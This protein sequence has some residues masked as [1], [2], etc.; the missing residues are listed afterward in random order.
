VKNIKPYERSRLQ[1]GEA[2][3]KVYTPIGMDINA[4]TPPEIG[5]G[6]VAELIKVMRK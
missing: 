4:R 5:I 3:K 6:I 1:Y 2:I